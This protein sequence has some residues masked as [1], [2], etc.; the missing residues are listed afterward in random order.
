MYIKL[1]SLT[2]FVALKY[3]YDEEE[4]LYADFIICVLQIPGAPAFIFLCASF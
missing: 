1:V 4:L 2:K 3:R